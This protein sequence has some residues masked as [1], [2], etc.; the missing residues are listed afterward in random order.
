MAKRIE[1]GHVIKDDGIFTADDMAP[2]MDAT[3]YREWMRRVRGISRAAKV[4]MDGKLIRETPQGTPMYAEVEYG[5]WVVNCE[6]G[7]T[8]NVTPNDPIVF[9]FS[10]MNADNQFHVRPVIFPSQK[11]QK[12]V[13]AALMRRH[14][15]DMFWRANENASD[16][17]AQNQELQRQGKLKR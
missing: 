4:V 13:E 10:C 1:N 9:C 16:L 3:T 12:N 15:K 8:E 2:S 17:D 7:G 5:R 11:D 14:H 6:C